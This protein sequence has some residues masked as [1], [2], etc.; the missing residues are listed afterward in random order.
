[1]ANNPIVGNAESRLS[2]DV[3]G[4]IRFGVCRRIRESEI[5]DSARRERGEM[6]GIPY[7]EM[8]VVARGDDKMRH[9]S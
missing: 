9:E 3:L 2:V 6:T 1:M 8:L 5:V 4:C 7:T